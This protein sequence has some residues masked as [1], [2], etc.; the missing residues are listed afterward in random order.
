MDSTAS[1][2]VVVV[3]LSWGTVL[4]GVGNAAV[5]LGTAAGTAAA[6]LFGTA[7]HGV[8]FGRG[9]R[10]GPVQALVVFGTAAAT[11]DE[12]VAFTGETASASGFGA[13]RH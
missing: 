2:Y 10:D 11:A 12:V 6:V 5:I 3:V 13:R 4:D 1:G 9:G 7:V 8:V